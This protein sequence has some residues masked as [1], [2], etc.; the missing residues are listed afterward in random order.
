MNHCEFFNHLF[1]FSYLP[2][3]HTCFLFF[4]GLLTPGPSLCNLASFSRQFFVTSL[5][6]GK[7]PDLQALPLQARFEALA[8]QELQKHQAHYC[9]LFTCISL[10]VSTKAI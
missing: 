3:P 8:T 5:L 1:A 2:A 4:S 6:S 10:S 7:L 9:S